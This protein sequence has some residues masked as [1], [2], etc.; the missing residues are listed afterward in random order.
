LYA[1]GA[2][3]GFVLLL[4]VGR[5][6][7]FDFESPRETQIVQRIQQQPNLS[8]SNP[9]VQ[10]FY[11]QLDQRKQQRQ[12]AFRTSAFRTLLALG[13]VLLVLWLY[14]RETVS[15]WL[16]G[17]LVVLV[18]TIDLWGVDQQYFGEENFSPQ[19]DEESQIPTYPVDR[20]LKENVQESGGPGRFRVFP[21]QTPYSQSPTSGRAAYAS[22]HYQSAGGYHAAK[23]Q[24]YQNFLDQVLQ[25]S[26]DG[27]LNKKALDLLNVRY[28]IAQ[29]PLPGTEVVYQS[30][31]SDHVVLENPEAVP[32]G[33]L[34]GRTE[35]VD[36]PEETWRRLRDPSFQPDSL[37]LVPEELEAPVTP[38]DSNSTAEV[39]LE[40]YEPDEITWTV[41][42]DAPRLFVAS[43][44]Y[45]PA[46]WNAYLDGTQVPIHR[47][48]YLLR[49][50]HVPDGGHTLTMRF[51]PKS[52][53]YG[54]WI[55]GTS[56]ALV[57]GGIL[58]ILG[59]T[60]RRRRRRR[61]EANE[62]DDEG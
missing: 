14:R 36:G 52:D 18:V 47:V 21:L 22:Y 41:N 2:V 34:V 50:V 17:G 5:G 28:I 61:V 12:E 31:R 20:F 1:F 59:I 35:V 23:L 55:A 10:Q 54:L 51:E 32:R 39:A 27:S 43:E 56:T 29:E 19:R 53:R 44:I 58:G 4:L 37:A 13:A 57:Y 38:I 15:A 60:Y 11:Q 25:L 8:R 46:G 30:D 48:N 26:R 7:F 6:V 40:S 24:R 3:A 49:G 33:Y 62:L 9:Q 16:A 45:Y 42:T